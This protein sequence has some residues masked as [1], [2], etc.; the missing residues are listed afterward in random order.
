GEFEPIGLGKG[1]HETTECGLEGLR[2]EQT[3]HPAE[4]IVARDA[5]LQAKEE[6]QQPFLRLSKLLHLRAPVGSAQHRR[7]RD[8][9][10][11]QKLVPRVVCTRTRQPIKSRFEPLHPTPS[12]IRESPS[13]SVLP[14]NAMADP[15]PY[16]IP[17][18]WRGR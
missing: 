15:N 6:P 16:A 2:L 18:P 8:E 17:L 14:F 9:Q 1:R 7:Q 13:E 12:M 5:V 10:N 4:R 3:E 11:L